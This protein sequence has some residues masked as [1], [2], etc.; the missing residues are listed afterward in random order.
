MC[1][2][3]CVRMYLSAHVSKYLFDVCMS[4][5]VYMYG[6]CILMSPRR[7]KE[8]KNFSLT[9]TQRTELADYICIC[10]THT[11]DCELVKSGAYLPYISPSERI[12]AIFLQK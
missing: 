6:I 8:P 12:F 1:V 7:V 5:S 10:I 11:A 3:V 9:V 2:C 4:V